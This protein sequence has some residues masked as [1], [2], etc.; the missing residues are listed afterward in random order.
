MTLVLTHT[1]VIGLNISMHLT[2]TLPWKLS[3]TEIM[4]MEKGR[5]FVDKKKPIKAVT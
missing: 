5:K 1:P 3:L 4:H 2:I